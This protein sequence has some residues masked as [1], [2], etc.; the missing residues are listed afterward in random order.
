MRPLHEGEILAADVI[1]L[2]EA[3]P[4]LG[5][6]VSRVRLV[7]TRTGV[8]VLDRASEHGPWQSGAT[9][10]L[11]D[12]RDA[13]TRVQTPDEKR[14]YVGVLDIESEE[15]ARSLLT[16]AFAA[17]IVERIRVSQVR[18]ELEEF[19]FRRL[20]KGDIVRQAV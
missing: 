20:P 4:A 8:R 6:D 18:Q 10:L 5:D 1:V 12:F 19:L 9:Q 7:E 2:I 15:A 11:S 17:D 13:L 3:E 16:Y 14:Q